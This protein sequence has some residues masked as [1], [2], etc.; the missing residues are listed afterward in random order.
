[1]LLTTT[2]FEISLRGC[3][4]ADSGP[5]DYRTRDERTADERT[6]RLAN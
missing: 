6:R 3:A 4:L 5:A 1:L 2:R